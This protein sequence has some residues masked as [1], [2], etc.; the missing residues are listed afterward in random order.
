MT[1]TRVGKLHSTSARQN[2]H[3]MSG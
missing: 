2:K 1:T 3:L